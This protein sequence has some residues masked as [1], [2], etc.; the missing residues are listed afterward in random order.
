[1]DIYIIR[2]AHA[3]NVGQWNKNDLQRP[4]IKKEFLGQR[5][6]LKNFLEN[7]RNPTLLFPRGL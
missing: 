6:P 2:H 5:V 1:M 7:L 4:L 3:V